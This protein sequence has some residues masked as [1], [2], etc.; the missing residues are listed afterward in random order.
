MVV[1]VGA[2]DALARR[3]AV[4]LSKLDYYPGNGVAAGLLLEGFQL[5]ISQPVLV[6]VLGKQPELE[7][8]RR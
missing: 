6:R 3:R 7:L 5:F 4:P 1:A 2:Q 8:F